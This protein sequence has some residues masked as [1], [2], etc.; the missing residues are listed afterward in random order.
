MVARPQRIGGGPVHHAR[1]TEFERLAG[2]SAPYLVTPHLVFDSTPRDPPRAE[3][4]RNTRV[5]RAPYSPE[6]S[7]SAFAIETGSESQ[8]GIKMHQLPELLDQL[9]LR[10]LKNL[11][12]ILNAMRIQGGNHWQPSDDLRDQPERF[13]VFR[14]HLA[15]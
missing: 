4:R 13:Q 8:I 5:S 14:L 2:P 11:D 1:L 10:S 3:L 6:V 15:Q 9:I 7:G 12:E